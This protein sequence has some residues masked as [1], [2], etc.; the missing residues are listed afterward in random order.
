MG[1]KL[2]TDWELTGERIVKQRVQFP[3]CAA[4]TNAGTQCR[5]TKGDTGTNLGDHV[6]IHFP[7]YGPTRL[8]LCGRH[9]AAYEKDH[10]AEI[11]GVT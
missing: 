5:A 1:I 3:R 4:L 11:E 6:T 7:G 2:R 10:R 9:L 8:Y